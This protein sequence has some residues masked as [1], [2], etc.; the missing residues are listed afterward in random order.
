MR[1]GHAQVAVRQILKPR[2]ASPP[3]ISSYFGW[4]N[5][6]RHTYDCYPSRISPSPHQKPLLSRHCSF[7]HH[8]PVSASVMSSKKAIDHYRLTTDVR[9]RHYDL[10]IRTDLEKKKFFGFVKIECA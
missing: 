10:T 2:P 9:P 5:S 1:L 4:R 7:H 6:L 8:P 3:S